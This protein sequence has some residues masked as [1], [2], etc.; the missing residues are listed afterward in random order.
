MPY[1]LGRYTYADRSSVWSSMERLFTWQVENTLTYDCTLGERHQLT[2]LLGQSA[3]SSHSQNV[4]GS[5]YDI[6]DPSQP[7]IDTTESDDNSRSGLGSTFARPPA[8]V[9]FRPCEL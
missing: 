9:V 1:Y 6:S 7:W 4:G 5:S 3:Q 2:V 8:A